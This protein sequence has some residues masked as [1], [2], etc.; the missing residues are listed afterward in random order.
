MKPTELV[1]D[2]DDGGGGNI[3]DEAEGGGAVDVNDDGIVD[4]DGMQCNSFFFFKF[5]KFWSRYSAVP[6]TK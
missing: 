1:E 6:S 3:C 4:N 5:A 2:C